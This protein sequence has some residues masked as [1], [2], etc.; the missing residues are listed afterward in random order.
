[1]RR[2]L[3]F[4]ALAAAC[5]GDPTPQEQC[6][7]FATAVGEAARRCSLA[8]GKGAVEAEDAANSARSVIVKDC[9]KVKSIARPGELDE[10]M[11]KLRTARCEGDLPSQCV[12]Q[13]VM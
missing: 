8:E 2:L 4:C 9:Y 6:A 3:I 11:S 12:A 5:G 13:F 1:M 10:C 7:D